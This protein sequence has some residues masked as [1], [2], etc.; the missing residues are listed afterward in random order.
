MMLL[1]VLW[2]MI[3]ISPSAGCRRNV[4]CGSPDNT[5]P[6][7]CVNSVCQCGVGYGGALIDPGSCLLA[8]V[9]PP[10][11]NG[12]FLTEPNITVSASNG[13][14]GSTSFVFACLPR[15]SDLWLTGVVLSRRVIEVVSLWCVGGVLLL[16]RV[17][18]EFPHV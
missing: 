14:R 11:P 2:V 9:P 10:V 7:L 12:A 15:S 6:G 5:A 16:S 4:D 13:K 17:V 1:C 3:I 18:F 8:C